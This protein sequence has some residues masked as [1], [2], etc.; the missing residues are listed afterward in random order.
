MAWPQHINIIILIFI[1]SLY[2]FKYHL[3]NNTNDVKHINTSYFNKGLEV[4]PSEM[5]KPSCVSYDMHFINKIKENV[6]IS[7]HSPEIQTRLRDPQYL[8]LVSSLT[9]Q[10]LL[11]HQRAQ[12]TLKDGNVKKNI[13]AFRDNGLIS[14]NNKGNPVSLCFKFKHKSFNYYNNRAAC[15]QYLVFTAR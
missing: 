15:E 4:N 12:K 8:D 6:I 1:I 7:P 2:S 14:N 11:T 10:V 3:N 13:V 5:R 9:D